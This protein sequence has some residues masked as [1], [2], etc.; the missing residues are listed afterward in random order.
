MAASI[1]ARGGRVT[2]LAAQFPVHHRALTPLG[3]ELTASLDG[4]LAP[5]AA[6][7]AMWST[8]TGAPLDGR[9]LDARY[10]GD[11]LVAPVRFAPTIRALALAGERAFLEVAPAPVLRTAIEDTLDA[12]GISGETYEAHGEH[13]SVARA[14]A[15]ARAGKR[16]PRAPGAG[17]LIDQLAAL[18]GEL[19]GVA[20]ED[21]RSDA[22]FVA[23][24]FDSVRLLSLASRIR[25]TIDREISARQLFEAGSLAALADQLDRSATPAAAA[26]R[27]GRDALPPDAAE[28][29]GHGADA[30]APAGRLGRGAA[31][32]PPRRAAMVVEIQRPRDPV[33]ACVLFPGAGGSGLMMAPWAAVL[34]PRMVG[35]AFDPPGHG[36]D[37]RPVASELDVLL[38]GI[39]DTLR[40][41][42]LPI[43]LV[44]Y[45]FGCLLAYDTARRALA[46]SLPISHVVLSHG[47]PPHWWHA[48][49]PSRQPS[50]VARWQALHA[51]LGLA[52]LDIPVDRYVASVLA[53]YRIGEAFPIGAPPLAVATSLVASAEDE[54]YSTALVGEWRRYVAQPPE[55]VVATGGHF[56]VLRR[57]DNRRRYRALFERLDRHLAGL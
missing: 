12:L 19:L 8:V 31:P 25:Q 33:A 11:H 21:V 3:R 1:A 20:P 38:D 43:V 53:D 52:E 30:A 6:R 55:L 23:L 40:D 51:A 36:A 10:W 13:T 18:A 27:P 5:T 28:D 56:D 49:R 22:G 9:A 47:P 4:A 48:E 29:L 45:S 46:T 44:G 17:P 32:L 15:I 41:L 34:P 26:D 7:L 42:R 50:F 16:P 57:D 54:L 39:E 2:P 14:A 35:L 24:G 37:R